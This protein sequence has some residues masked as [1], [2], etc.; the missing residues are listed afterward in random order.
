MSD[1]QRHR[2]SKGKEMMYNYEKFNVSVSEVEHLIDEWVFSER[3]RYILKMKLLDKRT[4]EEVAE[5]FDLSDRQVKRIVY[6]GEQIIF[7]HIE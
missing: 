7:R 4:Y 6:K 2:E 5:A 1:L 3:D